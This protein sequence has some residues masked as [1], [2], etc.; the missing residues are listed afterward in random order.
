MEIRPVTLPQQPWT[1]VL[2][3]VLL[4]CSTRLEGIAITKQLGNLI[5]LWIVRE[6]FHILKDKS[7]YLNP[8]YDNSIYT[9][10]AIHESR[11][12]RIHPQSLNAWEKIYRFTDMGGF[13]FHWLSE[14][15]SQSRL[16]QWLQRG[17]TPNRRLL[18]YELF[19][20]SLEAL[21]MA[22]SSLGN[23]EVA[24]YQPLQAACRDA[25]ALAVTLGCAFILAAQQPSESSPYLVSCLEQW[26]IPCQELPST[27]AI[28]EI[29]QNLFRQLFV[30][31]GLTQLLWS[32]D[33][34]LSIIHLSVPSGSAPGL[35]PEITTDNNANSSSEF[36]R[37]WELE[38]IPVTFPEGSSPWEGAQ[39]YWYS[40][41]HCSVMIPTHATNTL[42][43]P[44]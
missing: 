15:V 27:D 10:S 3:P 21:A 26:G 2:D 7:L 20:Q 35:V 16:P 43:V 42:S 28:V 5:E 13:Q 24:F 30:N 19:A 29:E 14:E 34:Q 8:V 41:N 4:L 38:N 37:P 39:G 11:L 31:A 12:P 32:Q 33:I 36:D 6:F 25:A 22:S 1:C 40:L 17:E 9:D 44:Q 18:S 23:N